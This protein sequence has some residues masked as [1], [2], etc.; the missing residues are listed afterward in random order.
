MTAALINIIAYYAV[1]L[2]LSYLLARLDSTVINEYEPWLVALC[3][4]ISAVIAAGWSLV[5]L[6]MWAARRGGWDT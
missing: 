4:P 3:W 5:A 1:A 2:L 6:M